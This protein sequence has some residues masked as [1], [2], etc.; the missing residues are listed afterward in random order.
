M[1]TITKNIGIFILNHNGIEW[2]KQTIPN[3]LQYSSDVDIIIIDNHSTDQ[4]VNYIKTNFTNIEI[5]IN[6][7]NYGFSKGY[8]QVLLLETRYK[9]F[10]I[11]NN[12]VKV[13]H[14]WIAP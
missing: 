4:S 5:K 6:T 14:N 2:L 3:I 1:E 7:E 9:Y 11:L 12:D 10:I 8:N 13:T